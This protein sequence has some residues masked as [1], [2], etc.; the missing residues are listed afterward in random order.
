M[1]GVPLFHL[2]LLLILPLLL[3]YLF[4]LVSF[5]LTQIRYLGITC[6]LIMIR[7]SEIFVPFLIF[8]P[9]SVLFFLTKSVTFGILFSTLVRA[10]VVAKLVTLGVSPL[11]LF[12]LALKG[13]F[14]AKLL[15]LGISPL[16]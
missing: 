9:H 12:T 3:M 7:S 16:T 11:T 8:L 15:I 5:Y 1:F 4:F 10:T 2:A 6:E 14:A 13:A